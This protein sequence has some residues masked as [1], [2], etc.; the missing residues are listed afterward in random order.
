MTVDRNLRILVAAAGVAP[1]VKIGGL[2]DVAGSP[3][4]APAMLNN[5]FRIVMPRYRHIIQPADT[6]ADFPVTV[7]SR[8]ET[9]IP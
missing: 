7:G 5:D 9:A 4:E 3:P 1:S 6:Q 8:R 2:A